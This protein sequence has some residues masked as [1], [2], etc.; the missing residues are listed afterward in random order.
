[1]SILSLVILALLGESIWE[2]AKM[3]WQDGKL[4]LDRIGAIVIGELLAIGA[5][6][7][8]LSLAGVPLHIPY[9]GLILT[10]LLISRGANFVHD[11]LQNID[12]MRQ[13][14]KSNVLTSLISVVEKTDT[15]V[16]DKSDTAEKN[17]SENSEKENPTA[18]ASAGSAP[19]VPI[20]Q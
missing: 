9:L 18:E 6:I 7:D 14:T 2:T 11:L 12:N 16:K 3:I 19:T 20:Q 15:G 4:S 1:M 10:G 13:N 17:A 8:L 5:G